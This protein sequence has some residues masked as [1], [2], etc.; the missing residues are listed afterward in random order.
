MLGEHDDD[1][2]LTPAEKRRLDFSIAQGKAGLTYGPF[3]DVGRSLNLLTKASK[4]THRAT[5]QIPAALFDYL[6][7]EAKRLGMGVGELM[8]TILETH[9]FADS[10]QQL[11]MRA[12]AHREPQKKT[13]GNH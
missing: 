7:T 4:H 13:R 2:R 11:I 10:D 12:V 8:A 9:R 3:D 1:E 6:K 5:I